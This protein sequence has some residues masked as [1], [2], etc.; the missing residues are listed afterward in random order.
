M[1]TQHPLHCGIQKRSAGRCSPALRRL[2]QLFEFP[3][4][5]VRI[6]A[7][8]GSNISEAEPSSNTNRSPGCEYGM[9]WSVNCQRSSTHHRMC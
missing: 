6:Y 7:H 1:T 4:V 8:D 9:T 5:N 3:L 2:S